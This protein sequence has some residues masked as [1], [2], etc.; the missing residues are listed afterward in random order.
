MN[1]SVLPAI[2]KTL[3]Q[4]EACVFEPGGQAIHFVLPSAV[5]HISK[6]ILAAKDFYEAELLET[7]H[8]ELAPD[9]VVLDVGANLGN[10]T[11][12]FSKAHP[13]CKLQEIR[14]L[15]MSE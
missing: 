3:H 11:V 2:E 6:T 14:F 15:L 1:K 8:A 7:L 12:Y 4:R 10:H 13:R 5:D 9:D